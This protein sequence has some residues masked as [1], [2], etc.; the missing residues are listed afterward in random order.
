VRFLLLLPN[1]GHVQDL[2]RL[3]PLHRKIEPIRCAHDVP[4]RPAECR[5]EV[6]PGYE[7]E[8]TAHP[9]TKQVDLAL[10]DLTAPEKAISYLFEAR[11]D[12][13]EDE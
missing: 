7:T 13:Y 12:A 6:E 8:W 3:P 11:S 2:V 5:E 1:V 9:D 10:V 4:G